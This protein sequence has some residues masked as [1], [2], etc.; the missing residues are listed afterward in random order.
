[1][2]R[3][4][5]LDKFADSLKDVDI[6]VQEKALPEFAKDQ[7]LLRVLCASLN[8]TDLYCLAGTYG[9]FIPKQEPMIPGVSFLWQRTVVDSAPKL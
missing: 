6:E 1:M 7:V 9:A 3:F 2:S 4:L 8:A 5:K